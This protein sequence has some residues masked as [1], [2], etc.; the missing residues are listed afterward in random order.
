MW[1]DC[2]F[3]KKWL[4]NRLG[5]PRK[6][7]TIVQSLLQLNATS[8]SGWGYMVTGLRHHHHPLPGQTFMQLLG[9]LGQ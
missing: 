5:A 8:N 9:N 4:N 3:S 6:K 2:G 1:M 7:K